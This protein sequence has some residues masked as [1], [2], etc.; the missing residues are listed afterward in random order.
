M[1]DP[2]TVIEIE[3]PCC[4]RSFNPFQRYELPAELE[5]LA[6]ALELPVE[7]VLAM[8]ASGEIPQRQKRDAIGRWYGPRIVFMDD[9][10][11]AMRKSHSDA[12]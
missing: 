2:K 9:A 12:H 5:L 3:C 10:L 7:T 4:K 6:Q 1:N 8:L 11:R